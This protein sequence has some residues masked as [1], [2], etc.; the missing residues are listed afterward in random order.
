LREDR[1]LAGIEQQAS[2]RAVM[3]EIVDPSYSTRGS[4][5]MAYRTR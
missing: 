1:A 3:E 5:R 2:P 4:G